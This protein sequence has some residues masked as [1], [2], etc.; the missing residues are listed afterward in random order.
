MLV[1]V[2]VGMYQ[3]GKRT[4]E[5]TA[6]ASSDFSAA[7]PC[8]WK[9]EP[10]AKAS[11]GFSTAQPK[12]LTECLRPLRVCCPTVCFDESIKTVR[13]TLT[14]RKWPLVPLWILKRTFLHI[15]VM[16]KANLPLEVGLSLSGKMNATTRRRI[17]PWMS[18]AKKKKSA[19]YLSY[20]RMWHEAVF[21]MGPVAEPKPNTTGSSKNASGPVGILVFGGPQA[22]GD[23]PNQFAEV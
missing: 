4:R 20:V 1:D 6:K 19:L 11:S 17:R 18:F 3:I 8:K 15:Y 23:K 12:E 22:P 14:C 7:Q 9:R 16:E 10:T 5:P 13:D 21:R 2:V